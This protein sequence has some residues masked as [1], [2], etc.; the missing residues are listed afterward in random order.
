[1]GIL[2]IIQLIADWIFYS[3]RICTSFLSQ[4]SLKINVLHLVLTVL[5]YRDE[6]TMLPQ[7]MLMLCRI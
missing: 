5:H 1:M 7:A 3:K 2:S 6:N 4:W